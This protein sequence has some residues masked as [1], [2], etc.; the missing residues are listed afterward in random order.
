[1]IQSDDLRGARILAV[2]DTPENLKILR[3]CLEPEGYNLL[4]ATNGDGAIKV[5]TSAR[6]DLILLDVQMPGK[7]GFETCAILK[8]QPETADIPV[9]FVTALAETSALV[10]GF[11]V[12][13]IDYI[14]KPFQ[15][16]EVLARV[17]THLKIDFLQRRLEE[18]NASLSDANRA[19]QRSSERRS[20]FMAGLSH[21]FR[22]PLT[23]IMGFTELVIRRGEGLGEKQQDNLGRVLESSKHLLELVN[24]ILDISKMEAGKMNV[25][26][27]AV[28]VG[29]LVQSCVASVKVN[30]AAGVDFTCEVEGD[31]DSIQ[32]DA[33]RLRQVMLNLLSNAAKFTTEGAVHTTV[34][35]N[36]EHFGIDVQDTGTGIPEG[37]LELIF[38]EFH[39]VEGTDRNHKGTGLGLPITQKLC[40]LLG[41]EIKVESEVGKGSVFSV[42]LPLREAE[43]EKELTIEN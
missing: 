43:E 37:A 8:S 35:V 38:D 27:D 29:A 18:S 2:D 26:L 28:N 12:G 4:I 22:T 9:I 19:I 42:R 21:E 16:E 6:P 3:E 15:N 24:D 14:I 20:A 32:T 11:E 31:L 41:G 33:S 7:D 36:S 30:A 39:Q 10:K 25:D 23:S 17:S 5:A 1:M 40:E 13:G 34:S